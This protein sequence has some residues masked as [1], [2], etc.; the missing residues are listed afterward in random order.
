MHVRS[1]RLRIVSSI[2]MLLVTAIAVAQTFNLQDPIPFDKAVRTATLANGL[3]YFVRRNDRPAMRVSLRLAVKTGSV[4]EQDDQQGLAHLI[5][6]MAFNG[7]EHFKP[8]ELVSYFESTGARLGPH[9][10]A[11]TSFDETVYMFDVPTDKPEVEIGRAH[12]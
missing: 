11:Y 1:T 8:G 4:N 2:G 7:S 10:N 5:E 12:V 6:H 3:A 9:V